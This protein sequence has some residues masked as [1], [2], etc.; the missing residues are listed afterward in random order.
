MKFAERENKVIFFPYGLSNTKT[1]N[2]YLRILIGEVPAVWLVWCQSLSF[3]LPSMQPVVEDIPY[4]RA[5]IATGNFC[6]SWTLRNFWAISCTLFVLLLWT[7]GLSWSLHVP[8][9]SYIKG[10]ASYLGFLLLY[11]WR[12]QRNLR[13]S[14]HPD[15]RPGWGMLYSCLAYILRFPAMEI[16]MMGWNGEKLALP[17]DWVKP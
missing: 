15:E 9:V 2:A 16:R 5:G 11:P 4:S 7:T 1:I 6:F 10:L 13:S 17:P 3:R 14:D 12:L 8:L